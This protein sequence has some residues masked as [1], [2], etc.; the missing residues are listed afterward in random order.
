MRRPVYQALIAT[1]ALVAQ[2][3]TASPAQ[4]QDAA[5]SARA[6]SIFGRFASTQAP[7][8]AVDVRRG[9]EMLLSRGYGQAELEH[10]AAIT[11][12][13]VFE[14]GSVSKQVTAAAIL[15]LA[16]RGSLSLDD[17]LQR[18]FPEIPSYADAITLRHLMLHTSGL[19]DWGA[20]AMLE[21]WPRGTR[22]HR[23]EHAL[24]I[25]ARQLGVNHPVG[26]E[27]S[28]T[29][30][31]Y[32]LLAILVSRVSGSSFA[33]FTRKEFFA[34]L[35]MT[36]TSWRDD[37]FRLVR[38]RAQ[39]YSPTGSG[40]W[41]LDMPF[42]H[43]HGNGGL[44]T[45]VGDLQRWTDAIAAGR[46]GS[47]D[48]S[49]RMTQ[50]GRLR[51][52]SGAGYGGG[53]FLG[54]VYGVRA[55]YHG[56][57]TAGYRAFLARFP[58]TDIRVAMLCNR[59]DA[60]PQV[61]ARQLLQGTLPFVTATASASAPVTPVRIVYDSASFAEYAGVYTSDEAAARWTVAVG[62]SAVTF[63]RWPGDVAPLRPVA[64]DEFA[65]PGG[66]RVVYTRDA[67]GRITG[68]TVNISRALGV[69]F[70]RE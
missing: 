32:N 17:T 22:D 11:P 59:G 26:A 33:E 47:P 44:L 8:C 25:A 64:R 53:L 66:M 6:D 52:G 1:A 5:L 3:S 65:A 54:D 67:S 31:G 56:G 58:D 42:E 13:T 9:G 14:A 46:I 43:V 4:A 51:D 45:T 60:A 23:Q 24:T 41:R 68:F 29:N 40:A 57:A 37:P 55:V 20:V 34:P 19:R 28:Y 7:G 2:I 15:L 48:V 21:G 12:T 61:L 35:E 39:G 70:T 27:F 36:S 10:G 18:W 62:S 16:E 38:G 49:K 63:A 30:T 50:E 69:I